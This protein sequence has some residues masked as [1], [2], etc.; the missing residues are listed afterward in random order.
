[1]HD[2]H[3]ADVTIDLAKG[4]VEYHATNHEPWRVTLVET[5]GETMTGGRLKR[6][7]RYL[8]PHEPFFLSAA[9]AP[10]TST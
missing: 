2:A 8:A 1:M 10:S 6:V 9:T 3:N 5:G 4:M 7:E